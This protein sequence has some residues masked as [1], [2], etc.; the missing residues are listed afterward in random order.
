M[1]TDDLHAVITTDAIAIGIS[2][3][4]FQSA[5]YNEDVFAGWVFGKHHPPV[6]IV[7]I[8]M[9]RLKEMEKEIKLAS[10]R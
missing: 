3:P 6:H 8:S 5:V 2:N 9:K 7:T 4:S 1:Y 10:I